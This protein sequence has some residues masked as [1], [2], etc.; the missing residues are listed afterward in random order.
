LI[1]VMIPHLGADR[2]QLRRNPRFV[3]RLVEWNAKEPSVSGERPAGGIIMRERRFRR[4]LHRLWIPCVFGAFAFGGF[5]YR[6]P[7]STPLAVTGFLLLV[8]FALVLH[9]GL[10]L[11]ADGIAW[12]V[13]HPRCVYR[14]VPWAAVKGVRV[15]WLGR[16]IVLDV[17]PGRYEPTLWGTPRSPFMIHTRELVRG[18]E[19]FEAINSFHGTRNSLHTSR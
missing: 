5:A 12:Y 14:R 3:V 11:T 19:V 13:V 1:E 7:H 4:Q 6:V 16:R 18:E 15:G 9:R 2:D 17:V 10:I 8:A